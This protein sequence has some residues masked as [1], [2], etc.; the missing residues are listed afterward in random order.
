MSFEELRLAVYGE[1]EREQQEQEQE[2]AEER[3]ER[4]E[5]ETADVIARLQEM[6]SK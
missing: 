3:Q 5:R 6:G 4:E 2:T 1:A